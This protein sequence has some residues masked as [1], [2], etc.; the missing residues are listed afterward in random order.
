M[1]RVKVQLAASVRG[2]QIPE[3]DGAVQTASYEVVVGGIQSD[4]GD[5]ISMAAKV[6]E[7]AIVVGRQIPNGVFSCQYVSK[8]AHLLYAHT[9]DFSAGIDDG[10][11]MVRESS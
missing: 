6:S 2:L 3:A 8:N 9:V 4:A 11:R 5:G 1:G 10:L 7:K